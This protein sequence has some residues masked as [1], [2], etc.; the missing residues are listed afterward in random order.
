MCIIKI[1][2]HPRFVVIEKCIA[3]NCISECAYETV[4]YLLVYTN[5]G[6]VKQYDF[7]RSLWAMVSFEMCKI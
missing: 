2:L 5:L 7:M 4:F 3:Y 6:I 1:V